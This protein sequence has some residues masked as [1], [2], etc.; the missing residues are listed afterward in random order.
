M[1]RRHAQRRG[2]A[3]ALS[4]TQRTTI[5]F[6]YVVTIYVFKGAFVDGWRL[7]ADSVDLWYFAFAGLLGFKLLSNPFFVPPS[8]ALASA[9]AAGLVLVTLNTSTAPVAI[10]PVLEAT[11][12]LG[13]ALMTMAGVAAII[14]TLLKDADAASSPQRHLLARIAYRASDKLGRSE[15]AFTFPAVISILGFHWSRPATV[16]FLLTAW[17]LIVIVE[18]IE[19]LMRVRNEVMDFGA[20]RANLVGRIQRVDSPNLIRVVLTDPNVWDRSAVHVATL[21]NGEQKYVL[22]LFYQIQTLT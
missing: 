9:I 17:V 16:A 6:L 3:T 10:V 13:I 19:A 14:A 15:V 18:P 11:R 4:L 5:F 1:E 8:E 7:T 21:A 12:Y 22:P 2:S 20:Q